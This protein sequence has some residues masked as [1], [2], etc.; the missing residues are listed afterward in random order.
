MKHT[1]ITL[2]IIS[3]FGLTSAAMATEEINYT[4]TQTHG[5]IEFRDYDE[6]VSATVATVGERREAIGNAFRILFDYIQGNNVASQ[7]IAMTAPVSQTPQNIAMTAPVSQKKRADG[8]W[9][10]AFYMPNDMT[11]DATPKPLDERITINRVAPK[12]MAAITFSGT[13]SDE[14]VAEHE[15]Q[16]RDFLHAKNIT[17][18]DQPLYAFYNA[19]YVPWFLRRNEV[20]FKLAP[21]D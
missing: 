8:T 15:T 2:F 11:Y 18:I 7:S 5:D 3:F 1:R 16:L 19:P 9:Q 21:K 12:S 14:N 20:L 6:T 17:F 10:V 4:V 13:S